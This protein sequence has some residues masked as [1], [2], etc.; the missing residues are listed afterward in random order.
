MKDPTM[1]KKLS[2]QFDD[3]NVLEDIESVP[4]FLAEVKMVKKK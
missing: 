4:G 1:Y 3:L 2:K